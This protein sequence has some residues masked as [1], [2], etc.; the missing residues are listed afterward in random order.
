MSI[1]IEV[2]DQFLMQD[3]KKLAKDFKTS[4]ETGLDPVLNLAV[5]ELK[6][7]LR[8]IINRDIKINNTIPDSTKKLPPALN[9]PK[10]KV[11]IIKEVFGQDIMSS[12][13]IRRTLKENITSNTSKVF[14]MKDGRLKSWQ[15]VGDS[16]SYGSQESLFK[17]RLKEGIIYDMQSGKL[18]KPVPEDVKGIKVECST[19]TG[20]TLNSE[21]K[22]NSYK[23]SPN[24]TRRQFDSPYNRVAVWTVKQEDLKLMTQRAIDLDAI[25]DKIQEGEYETVIKLFEQNNKSGVFRTAIDNLQNIKEGKAGTP[26]AKSYFALLTLIKNIKIRKSIARSKTTYTLFTNYSSSL[27]QSESG[28]LEESNTSFFHALRQEIYLW[29]VSNEEKWLKTIIRSVEKVIAKYKPKPT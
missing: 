5:N 16:D 28:M 25:I 26:E 27:D 19:D 29:K 20:Q 14:V 3:I 8:T 23:N 24:I 6:T 4:I 2:K 1:K 18:L 12:D 15:S 11:D 10:S 7:N 17:S 9:L 13:F 21:N 22:F